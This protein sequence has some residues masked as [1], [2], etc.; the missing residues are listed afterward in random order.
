MSDEQITNDPAVDPAASPAAPSPAPAEA[1]TAE[2]QSPFTWGE[3][4]T[5]EGQA[6]V[7]QPPA[8]DLP[9]PLP[10]AL[11]VPELA[12]PEHM[13]S[14]Q[15]QQN[16][17]Q[18][19]AVG[20]REGMTLE[21]TQGLVSIYY[22]LE[23]TLGDLKVD[24]RDPDHQER[25]LAHLRRQWGSQYNENIALARKSF[26][27]LSPAT[28]RWLNETG[29]GDDAS[30]LTILASLGGGIFKVTP[31]AAKRIA[32]VMRKNSPELLNQSHPDHQMAKL[33]YRLLRHVEGRGRGDASERSTERRGRQALKDLKNPP[34][35]NSPRV[36]AETEAK[37]LM[38]SE[39]WSDKRNAAHKAVT[40]RVAE[41][42]MQAYPEKD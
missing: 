40:A 18:L 7:D 25:T 10:D 22:E 17:A 35:E 26:K 28:Q 1:P 4:E 13:F 21:D 9:A 27:S 15:V 32:D 24:Q 38:R 30:V 5:T 31:D 37:Q 8:G 39:A 3:E 29:A 41:L 23:S 36:K 6:P 12:P 33:K 2:P 34:N 19:A 11:E 14:E 16:L 20:E 42:F